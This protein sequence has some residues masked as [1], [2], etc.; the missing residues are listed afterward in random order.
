MLK[1]ST[2]L[3]AVIFAL[4]LPVFATSIDDTFEQLR[5][6]GEKYQIVG[7]VCEQ[8]ARLEMQIQYPAPQYDVLTGIAYRAGDKT[9]GELDVIVFESATQ[10]AIL[11]GEV[12][13]WNNLDS[14]LNKAHEQR[15]RFMKTIK[16]GIK[17]QMDCTDGS[18]HYTD[19]NF[20]DVQTFVT[21]A[22]QG[23]L[24]H[25]FD[26]ELEYPLNQLMELRARLMTCQEQGECKRPE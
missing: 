1:S 26:K 16:K 24:D 17:L 25:G 10:K 4:A 7:T 18:C 11:V 19:K 15:A 20:R 13:C 2:A 14:A 6:S 22:Q 5:D 9:I 8:V 12:K 3:F 23:A 21:I